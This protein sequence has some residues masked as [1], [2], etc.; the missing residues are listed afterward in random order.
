MKKS[1]HLI[2]FNVLSVC[3]LLM[4]L[5]THISAIENAKQGDILREIETKN[6]TTYFLFKANVREK[7]GTKVTPGTKIN[8]TSYDYDNKVI[9]EDTYE[10]FESSDN[11]NFIIEY[12]LLRRNIS[13]LELTVAEDYDFP[14]EI[15]QAFQSPNMEYITYDANGGLFSDGASQNRVKSYQRG[16][17]NLFDGYE[18]PT[19]ETLEFSHWLK[20]GL[21]EN[22][23]WDLE[24]DL[25]T[26]P[27]RFKA[28]WK[29]PITLYNVYFEANNGLEL[30]FYESVASGSTI[31]APQVPLYE[32]HQFEGWYRD[33][34]LTQPWQFDQD[35]IESDTTLYAKWSKEEALDVFEVMFD[36]QGGSNIGEPLLVESGSVI[37]KPENPIREGYEFLGWSTSKDELILWNFELDS[38]EQNTVLYAHWLLTDLTN[39]NSIKPIAPGDEDFEGSEPEDGDYPIDVSGLPIGPNQSEIERVNTEDPMEIYKDQEVLIDAKD[40]ESRE[41]AVPF[42]KETLPN[43]GISRGN[44]IFFGS[45]V[46]IIGL[47]FLKKN[48]YK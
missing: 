25:I 14:I 34:A 16:N 4:G 5:T 33:D 40:D 12:D 15:G 45:V 11:Y 44:S 6:P 35:V 17:L 8:V 13:K 37:E 19:H 30:Q 47:F 27:H 29:E 32:G 1:K 31:I 18:E 28:V 24:N 26:G 21:M 2:I 23:I 43:L 42:S 20:M 3:L 38:I 36:S 7:I 22:V 10:T 39:D 48:K 41:I 9:A 46:A